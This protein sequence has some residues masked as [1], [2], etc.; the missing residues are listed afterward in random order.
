MSVYR[1]TKHNGQVARDEN[2]N[3]TLELYA[4]GDFAAI[5]RNSTDNRLQM[6]VYTHALPTPLII[7]N[8]N[9]DSITMSALSDMITYGLTMLN[10]DPKEECHI[11]NMAARERDMKTIRI[12]ANK[13][14]KSI[15]AIQNN[16]PFLFDA[17]PD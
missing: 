14:I 12:A 8:Q 6:D 15:T 17:C 13:A 7:T 10:Y 3:Y 16:T 1:S 9:G 4:L 2:H 5:Y 11:Y